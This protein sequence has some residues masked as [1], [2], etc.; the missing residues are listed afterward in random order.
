MRQPAP[1]INFSGGTFLGA[2]LLHGARKRDAGPVASALIDRT[3]AEPPAGC[4]MCDFAAHVGGI[5]PLLGFRS[6]W[7]G[8]EW[9]EQRTGNNWYRAWNNSIHCTGGP[10]RSTV[11]PSRR[12]GPVDQLPL[13]ISLY[14]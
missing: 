10:S 6:S 12:R 3:R 8:A 1:H 11:A 5:W 9:Q 14:S 2:E 7:R 4:T 13:L